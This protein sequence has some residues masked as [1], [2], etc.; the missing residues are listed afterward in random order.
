MEIVLDTDIQNTEKECSTHNVLCTLPVYRG[1]RYT[2]LRAREL[3]SIRSH[4]KATRIQKNLAAAELARR[5]YIDSEVLGV[6]FDITLH[7]IDRLST[8]YMHKFINEFD[9]EHGISSWCNQLVKEA[10]IANPDAIHLNECVINHNGISFTFRSND[11][12]K[13]SLVLITIS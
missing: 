2:R 13:N 6:T 5:N 9:G 7:A 8:L 1:Q 4:S 12:V 3:K 11:Y 10:L